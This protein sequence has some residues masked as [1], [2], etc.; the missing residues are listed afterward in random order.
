MSRIHM[1]LSNVTPYQ[2]DTKKQGQDF[3]LTF[4][5][6][7]STPSSGWRECHCCLAEKPRPVSRSVGP[8]SIYLTDPVPAMAGSAAAVAAA[9]AAASAAAPAA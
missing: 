9:P 7:I 2:I 6:A 3:I 4:F 5:I 8:A 1:L